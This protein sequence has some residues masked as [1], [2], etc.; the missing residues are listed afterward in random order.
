MIGGGMLLC[1][2]G[3]MI[4]LAVWSL[5]YDELPDAKLRDGL[6]A[7]RSFGESKRYK[8]KSQEDEIMAESDPSRTTR[9]LKQ[10]RFDPD[11]M[12]EIEEEAEMTMP[13]FLR[14]AREEY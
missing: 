10:L 3:A 6:L 13:K 7:L 14:D 5:K 4:L 2:V 8:I 12:A 9:K 1:A 11:E